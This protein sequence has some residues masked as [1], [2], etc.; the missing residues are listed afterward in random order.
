MAKKAAKK[1]AK[2]APARKTAKKA[3]ARKTAKKV[4]DPNK[5]YNFIED[6]QDRVTEIATVARDGSI[7]IKRTDMKKAL[8]EAFETAATMA[9]KGERVRFPVIGA[10]SRKDVKA[11]KAGKYINPFTK[12]EAMRAA[13][14]ASKKPR[15]SFPKGVKEVFSNKR[16]WK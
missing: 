15:W 12:E 3:P 4:I 9:A 7:R 1:V 11:V 10:L 8:E 6:V 2:K 14:P 5:K 13:R 16:N